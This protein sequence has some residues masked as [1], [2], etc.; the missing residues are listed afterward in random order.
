VIASQRLEIA[1]DKCH[2]LV[3]LPNIPR[4]RICGDLS[5]HSIK[6][7]GSFVREIAT[8]ADSAS[9]V[10][11]LIALSHDLSIWVIGEGIETAEQLHFLRKHDCDAG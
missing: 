6:I 10:K 8:N 3:G 9:I 11:S 2:D 4:S 7:D 1:G 5:P